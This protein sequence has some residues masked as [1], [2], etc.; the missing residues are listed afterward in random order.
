MKNKLVAILFSY[1]FLFTASSPVFGTTMFYAFDS[2]EFPGIHCL[3]ISE[4]AEFEIYEN[5]KFYSGKT[6]IAVKTKNEESR[7][8]LNSI[9]TEQKGFI[10]SAENHIVFGSLKPNDLEYPN[11]W[12]SRPMNLE[13]AW[14]EVTGNKSTYVAVFDTGID[15]NDSELIGNTA[16]N[17]N[18]SVMGYNF[19]SDNPN[20]MDDQGHGSHVSGI[21][22]ATGNNKIGIAGV[23]WETSIIP[24]KVLGSNKQGEVQFILEGIDWLLGKKRTG[25]N[26][27]VVNMSLH[28]WSTHI[29]VHTNPIGIAF[30]A[31]GQ[32]DIVSCFSAG[33]DG[34]NYDSLPEEYKDKLSYPACFNIQGQITVGAVDIDYSMANFSNRSPNYVHVAAPGVDI[35]SVTGGGKLE[36]WK[37]TSMAA[38]QVAGVA[39]LV[40]SKY[41]K[42]SNEEIKKKI[43][44]GAVMYSTLQGLVGYGMLNAAN[45][46]AGPSVLVDLVIRSQDGSREIEINNSEKLEV[47]PYPA[48]A[49]V[50]PDLEWSSSNEKIL[51]VEQDGTAKG[52]AKGKVSITVKSQ[53]A[54]I[55]KTEEFSVVNKKGESLEEGAGCSSVSFSGSVLF[56][57]LP[58]LVVI[59]KYN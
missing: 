58:L 22:G 49:S 5:I 52:I 16:R 40:A 4:D 44:D 48:N 50:P 27:K 33:N 56:L 59:F 37:G 7:S 21:L 47:V 9:F 15:Y 53:T 28:F 46:V 45:A 20:P 55:E 1:L 18:G 12:G 54:D 32:A 14:D 19:V 23:N 41:P 42:A 30:A 34:F 38:P 17:P 36:P 39:A 24:V 13:R 8:S 31:L 6:V 29:D 57:L 35:W 10:G 3:K 43:L 51:V 26:V 2:Q 25:V 11:Q